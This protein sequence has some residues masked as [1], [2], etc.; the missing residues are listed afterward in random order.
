VCIAVPSLALA[1]STRSFVIDTSE[2]FDKGKFDGVVSHE[3]GRLTRG[4]AKER[5]AVEGVP[6]AYASAV[7]P[8]GAVYVGTGSE[9][10][11]MRVGQ[12]AATR[13]ADTDAALITSL[14]WNGDTLYAGAL[15]KGRVLALDRKGTVRE[16][17]QLEGAEHVWS[18]AYDSK[19]STLYAAT[20]PQ[21]KLFAIDTQGKTR[22]VHDDAAEHLLS[23]AIDDEGRIWVGTSNGGRLV[24]IAGTEVSVVRDF[25]AEELTAIATKGG[26]VAVAANDFPDP[27]PTGSESNRDA[28]KLKR[29]KPGKGKLFVIGVD[30]NV[31]QLYASDKTHISAVE[32]D[33]EGQAVF[34]GLGQD[35]RIVRASF[36]GDRALWMDVDERQV[37]SLALFARVPHFVTSDGVA[38]YRVNENASAGTWTSESLDTKFLAR[39]GQLTFRSKGPLQMQTRSGNTETPDDSWT[40]FAAPL[41]QAGPIR[42]PEGRFL[43]VRA[44]LQDDAELYGVTA[45]YLPRNQ[46]TRVTNVR[47][48]VDKPKDNK[49]ANAKKKEPA[50]SS[51][52]PLTWD[53]DNPD[54]DRLRFRVSYRRDHGTAF[55]PVHPEHE[56]LEEPNFEWET[57]GVPDG[58]YRIRVQASDELAN[59]KAFVRTAEALSAPLLVDNHAP[60]ISE[61]RLDNRTVRGRAVDGVG[62]VTALDVSIDG[63]PSRPIYPDD[64]LLDTAN[65]LFAIEL[66]GLA[67]GPHMVTVRATDA[68]AN[69]SSQALEINLSR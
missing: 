23:L 29:P 35:G 53:V 51:L 58:L 5:V 21:G 13:F 38:L 49:D 19:R 25:P 69:V 31:E 39:F 16:L 7:G 41:E 2:A 22:V 57:R 45:Y 17:A 4:P 43:Q 24:R 33:I 1:V 63:Q 34:A 28:N 42:S 52:V 55:L 54:E 46:A 56:L 68:A 36:N 59:P 37:I 30:G 9:G 65:E 20:G 14:V 40:P 15:P 18:V 44:T 50:A 8:D 64:Q 66:T 12:T 60:V 26:V 27:I 67:H 11:I 10:L 6:V 62:P 47:V 3:D 61:L 48:K 32:I